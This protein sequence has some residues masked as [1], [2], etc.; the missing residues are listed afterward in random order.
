MNICFRGLL[1]LRNLPAS[2]LNKVENFQVK[3]FERAR[4]MPRQIRGFVD[5]ATCVAVNCVTG[6]V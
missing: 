4:R 1:F 6:N 3:K 5:L 2:A